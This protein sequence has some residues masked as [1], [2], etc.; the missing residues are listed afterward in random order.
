MMRPAKILTWIADVALG[1]SDLEYLGILH[2]DL[3][4]RNT[5]MKVFVTG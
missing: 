2:T 4:F 1:I 5:I 3:A